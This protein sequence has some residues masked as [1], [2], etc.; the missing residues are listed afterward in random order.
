MKKRDQKSI[1]RAHMVPTAQKRH[2][3]IPRESDDDIKSP[4]RRKLKPS[5]KNLLKIFF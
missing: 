1:E 5:R 2:N 3:P 4:E